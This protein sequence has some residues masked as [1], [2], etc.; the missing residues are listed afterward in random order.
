MYVA[1]EI[2]GEFVVPGSVGRLLRLPID[3]RI[4]RAC[5]STVLHGRRGSI[6]TQFCLET[7]QH[8]K[9]MEAEIG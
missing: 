8:F 3:F 6:A 2:V 1:E 9:G 5:I 4:A 7:L